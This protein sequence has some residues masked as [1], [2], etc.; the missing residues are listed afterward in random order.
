M[1]AHVCTTCAPSRYAPRNMHPLRVHIQHDAA[2]LPRA[3]LLQTSSR[4]P[5]PIC[6]LVHCFQRFVEAQ[7]ATSCEHNSCDQQSS[8][9]KRMVLPTAY[10]CLRIVRPEETY[11]AGRPLRAE[12]LCEK[13]PIRSGRRQFR[14]VNAHKSTGTLGQHVLDCVPSRIDES[15]MLS[16]TR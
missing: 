3:K 6:P 5:R 9:L 7:L 16:T 11:L 2:D 14:S 4:Q 13:S 12:T 10:G 8:G 15:A 1:C